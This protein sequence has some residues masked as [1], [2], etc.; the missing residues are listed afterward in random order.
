MNKS[1][2]KVSFW[3]Y[4]ISKDFFKQLLFLA[5]VFLGI[6]LL[7]NLFL[8]FYTH[9]GQKLEMPNII[10]K[11]LTD[12]REAADDNSFE[13]VVVDSI[14]IVGKP[15]GIIRDQNP[16]GGAKVKQGRK[17][18]VTVTKYGVESISVA[19]LPTLYGNP[20][21]QKKTELKYRDIDCVIKD[22]AY[23][24]GE[25]NHILEVYY[26]GELILSKDVK[27]SDVKIAKGEKLECIV[28]RKDG[29]DVTVPDLR[30]LDL[31][32]ATFLLE[33]NKL[34]IGTVTRKGGGE[35]D[36]TV[37]IIAQ[38]PQFDGITNIKMGEK[39]NLTVSTVKPTDCQ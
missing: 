28:S 33:T 1:S 39:V 17:I 15:G 31:D 11:S 37:Y 36:A 9:H 23:D 34:A 21:E 20:F 13:I 27:K 30:C 18:Y 26:K 14:F 3:R 29:G 12:A 32:E 2:D 16:K 25:P 6:V 22:Y 10:G 7:A 35:P 8:R 19:D 4:L 5:A 38:S 24:P